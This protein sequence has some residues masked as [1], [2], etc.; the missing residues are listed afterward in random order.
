MKKILAI[1]ITAA[2]LSG[3]SKSILDR[4]PND[5]IT[6]KEVFGDILITEKFLTNIYSELNGAIYNRTPNYLLSGTTDEAEIGIMNTGGYHFNTGS[7]SPVDFPLGNYWNIYYSAIRKANIFLANIDNVP[8]DPALVERMKGEA[9]FL[10]AWFY[11]Q[12]FK[13]FGTFVIV[14]HVLSVSDDL[15]LPR[16]SEAECAAYITSL[17]DR[18]AALL[19]VSY[20]NSQLGRITKGAALALKAE[21]LLFFASPLYNP[22]NDTQRWA[23]AA[24]AAAAVI[25]DSELGY[26]LYSNYTNL[27]LANHNEEVILAFNAGSG[28]KAMESANSPSSFGGNCAISPTQELVDAYEMANGLKPFND[29]GTVND[30]SGYNPDAPYA[31]RDPRFYATILYNGASWQ[32]RT[33]ESYVGGSDEI[34]VGSHTRSQTGYFLRKFLDESIVVNGPQVRGATWILFRLGTL[35]LDYAEARNEASGPDETVYQAVNRIRARAN[36]PELPTGLSK[37]EM[38]ERIHHERRIE[39]A[40]EDNRFWDVRRWKIGVEAFEKTFHGMRITRNGSNLNYERVVV[41]P[42]VFDERRHLFP[43]PQS[44]I[45]KNSELVQNP[46]W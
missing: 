6:E 43:L 18:A 4:Q 12:L 33:I 9:T 2:V 17:C 41:R 38:R 10:K 8:G 1:L 31:N 5:Q 19:P 25:N 11:Q 32:G 45:N 30:A 46:G 22:E 14:D 28:T 42:R 24:D 7:F 26:N 39:M 36:M 20:Q 27:F 3:C 34:A 29:D 23:N 15:N 13:A 37:A 44:E 16:G 35:L 40:F 21:C